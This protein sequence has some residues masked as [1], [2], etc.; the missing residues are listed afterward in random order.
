MREAQIAQ[1]RRVVITSDRLLTAAWLLPLPQGSKTPDGSD[2]ALQLAGALVMEDEADLWQRDWQ[3][4]SEEQETE[5]AEDNEGQ[6][7][8][9]KFSIGILGRKLASAANNLGESI[10]R[11]AAAAGELIADADLR[12]RSAALLAERCGGSAARLLAACLLPCCW[13]FA[14]QRL[15]HPCPFP[16]AAALRRRERAW[17]RVR[18]AC[19]CCHRCH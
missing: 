10:V 18:V 16:F 8:R 6:P 7:R 17:P 11:T 15:D 13:V 1:A 5:E 14:V 3:R 2:I 19:C 9:R 4:D 12:S